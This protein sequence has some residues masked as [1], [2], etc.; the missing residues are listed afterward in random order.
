MIS[1]PRSLGRIIPA[2]GLAL[3]A[4]LALGAFGVASASAAVPKVKTLPVVSPA[5]PHPG[6]TE[7][8]TNGT[9]TENPTSYEYQW[10]RCEGAS[11]ACTSISG[12]KSST[13]IPVQ[14]DMGY[15]LMAEVTAYNASGSGWANSPRTNVLVPRPGF[16]HANGTKLAE[17]SPKTITMKATTAFTL[18]WS[19][20]GNKLKVT[21]GSLN[22]TEGNIENPA[23]GAAGTLQ[24]Y[25][26]LSSC[27]VPLI[28]Q[29]CSVKGGVIETGPL[30][31]K[32]A[33]TEFDGKPTVNT[34]PNTNHWMWVT[35]E[36][37][38]TPG[39]NGKYEFEGS[40]AGFANA[41]ASTI[42]FGKAGGSL[43]YVLGGAATFEGT[44]KLELTS[45][46][47]LTLVL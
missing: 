20:F 7:T 18:A 2:F 31:V 1:K 32:G 10:Y 24:T 43:S 37:C 47:A 14:A 12:A 44:S 29:H 3:V 6:V 30:K 41:A 17:G 38:A 9:W 5:T 34:G 40:I 36:G 8:T 35:I 4:S 21:C 22:S 15:S 16:W 13:Y 39:Y 19:F 11:G 25:L 45:G 46:E 28:G 26:S 42:E 27:T 33:G 23:A